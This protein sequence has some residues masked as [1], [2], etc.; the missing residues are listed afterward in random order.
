[1]NVD[2]TRDL[3][4]RQFRD[5]GIIGARDSLFVFQGIRPEEQFVAVRTGVSTPGIIE[6]LE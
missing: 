3:F 5:R 2:A 6:V 4:A 1:M